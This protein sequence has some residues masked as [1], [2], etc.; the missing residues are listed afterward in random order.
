MRKFSGKS[1]AVTI[2][3]SLAIL[4]VAGTGAAKASGLI[5]TNQIADNAITTT[6]IK[7][8]AITLVD[9]RPSALSRL[10]PAPLAG[11]YYSVA[12]YD[13][14]DTNA[15]AIATVACKAQTDVAISGGIQTLGLQDNALQHNTPVSNSFPGRMDFTT[16]TPKPGR[17]DGWIVQ[18]GGNAGQVSDTSPLKTKIWALCV[19][20]ASIPVTQTYQ[21]SSSS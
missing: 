10:M 8:G 17:L 5:G 21:E 15:G 13:S 16:N 6:K 14:G 19:P 3:A 4:A 7:D 2:G 12:Y 20:G 9:M 11:A 1:G 18:F